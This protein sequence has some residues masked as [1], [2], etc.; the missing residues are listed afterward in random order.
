MLAT[1]SGQAAA[2]AADYH[3]VVQQLYIS[4]F[5]RPADTGGLANF[6]ARL[7]DM[8]APA[9]IQGLNAAYGTSATVRE[10]IDSF[11]TSAESAALYGTGDSNAFITAI[12][13]NV[14]S[15]AP[16][17]EGKAFWVNALDHGGM[18]RP[19]AS[20]SIMAG[21]LKNTTPQGLQD[22]IL[23]SKRVTVGGNFTVGLDTPTEAAAYSGDAAAAVART[24][25]N[26]VHADTDV[27]AYQGTVDATIAQLVASSGP[28]YSQVRAIINQRCLSCHND[29]FRSGGNS[30]E[31]DDAV[32]AQAADIYQA[33]VVTRIMPLQ[34][35]TGMTQAER[36]VIKAWFEAGA[37]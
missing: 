27:A 19:N 4:Y 16:D 21:A 31:H 15:R 7:A 3:T 24:M 18:T 23:I 17:D 10:L 26:G 8:Q 35:A 6:S 9:D 34:N 30:W 28:P 25:L 12:Y 22:G 36:D 29:S 14:L 37:K 33:V 2:V 20:L 32:H 11:G 5:G 13:N 1:Q